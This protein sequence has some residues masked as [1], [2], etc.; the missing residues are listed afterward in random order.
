[1]NHTEV[2]AI[3][4]KVLANRFGILEDDI[5]MD[6]WDGIILD[7]AERPEIRKMS[8]DVDAK[9]RQLVGQTMESQGYVHKIPSE[10]AKQRHHDFYLHAYFRGKLIPE[11]LDQYELAR[12]REVTGEVEKFG[13]RTVASD[14]MSRIYILLTNP[15]FES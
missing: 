8:E 9:F 14:I 12:R 7:F 4:R 13:V 11:D 6:P 15:W 1:M 3:C 5:S 10:L 2:A